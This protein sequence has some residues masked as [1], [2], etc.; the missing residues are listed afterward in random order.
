[1]F[2]RIGAEAFAERARRELLATGETVRKRTV[3]TRDVLTAQE[4]QIARLAGDG[5]TN[6][7]IGA[8]LFI[9]PRTV[10][11]HLRKVFTKL[12]ITSRR[13]LP[14][15]LAQLEQRAGSS[16]APGH[17]SPARGPGIP[18]RDFHGCERLTR[19]GRCNDDVRAAPH[20]RAR[21]R[22]VRRVRQLERR[23]PPADAPRAGAGRQPPS[24]FG[25]VVAVANPLRSLAGDAG[26]LR[27]VIDGIGGPVVLV[28]HSYGGMVI[29]EAAAATTPWSASST[30]P[31]FA[32]D[33]GE[34]AF[35]L[36]AMFP[37]STL[38]DA[39]AAY[40]VVHRRHE[41]AIRHEAFHHQFAADVPAEQAALMAAT[42]RP[43]TEAALV[44]RPALPTRRR[45]RTLPSWFVFGD[46]D[47]NIPVALHRFMAERAGAEGRREVRRR[48]ARAHASRS[49]KR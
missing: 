29:T 5:H 17:T 15:R 47:L 27:D 37:G 30:S 31:R 16:F 14:G 8:Q 1:M 23:H 46:Q 13:E 19:G 3:E 12:D 45:G 10:E 21:P 48:L 39:L 2:S 36:S 49:P 42:Q 38:G 28:G 33:H 6:P 7:E 35:E 44:G 32:P 25:D 41:L 26:Y 34:S 20:H 40:P 24:D 43:V 4:A 22:R 9:S 11:Y 18:T